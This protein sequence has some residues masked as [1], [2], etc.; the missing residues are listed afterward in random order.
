MARTVEVFR[1]SALKVNS[2]TDEE[3]NASER[4]RIERTSMMQALQRS[5]GEVVDA[6][7]EGDFSKRVD[8][9]FPD[10]E[11]NVIA[12]S[13]NNLVATVDRGLGET[14]QVLSALAQTDLTHRVEGDYS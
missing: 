6:A 11:L 10:R 9:E 12:A 5:F 7:V 8:A 13:I 3:R 4:R 14:G 1:E 2:L